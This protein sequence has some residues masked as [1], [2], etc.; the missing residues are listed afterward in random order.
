[1]LPK[2]VG[3]L[4]GAAQQQKAQEAEGTNLKFQ[5]GLHVGLSLLGRLHLGS[6][7]KKNR[8]AAGLHKGKS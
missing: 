1:M 6:A 4:G 5:H 8:V 2:G 7:M 3:M